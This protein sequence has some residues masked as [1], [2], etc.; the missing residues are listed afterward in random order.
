MCEAREFA[1]ALRLC[2]TCWMNS[3]LSMLA[4]DAEPLAVS[5]ACD[6]ELLLITMPSASCP[7]LSPPGFV[8]RLALRLARW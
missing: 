2:C 3:S 5:T 8:C 7:L 6:A 1:T 4:P